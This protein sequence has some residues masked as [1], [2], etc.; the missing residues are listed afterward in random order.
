MAS[1]LS[2]I[3]R[4][5]KTQPR[6]TLMR[7]IARFSVMRRLV[8]K[9]RKLLDAT[10]LEAFLRMNKAVMN[11]SVFEPHDVDRVVEG[12]RKNG[13]AFGLK[14]PSSVVDRIMA[15]THEQ[16]AFADRNPSL[17]FTPPQRKHLQDQLGKP[18]LL[19]QYF[20]S[21]AQCAEIDKLSRD[22]ILLEIAA[23]YLESTPTF[24]G[25]NIWWTYPV[26]ATDADR[27]QHAHVFH[28]DIDDFRFLK[29]F[30][31]LTDVPASEGA[32]VCVPGSHS[33]PPQI[34]WLDRWNIRRFSDQEIV[35]AYGKAQILE[36]CGLAGIGF[37]EDTLCVH[38][39]STPTKQARLLL[40]LQFALYDYGVM[41]DKRSESELSTFSI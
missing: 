11:K 24:V 32:H 33:N 17:G 28:R 2:L 38:K 39:G 37:A 35:D 20:N 13:V 8:Y 18:I 34:R 26:I 22:P 5:L 15:W 10:R 36:I 7:M 31:Y 3:L 16:P 21:T 40:Q 4:S 27:A 1:R 6:Y 14:V 30:F 41:H 9:T 19:A 29:F 23:R 12:L 25:A